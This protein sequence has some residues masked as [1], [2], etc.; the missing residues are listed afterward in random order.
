[1]D[2]AS[3]HTEPRRL[4]LLIAA[5]LA[6]ELVVMPGIMFDFL[7]RSAEWPVSLQLLV[8]CLPRFVVMLALVLMFGP[9]RKRLWFS[10]FLAAY[11]ALLVV[12]FYTAEVFVEWSSALAASRATFPYV[13]GVIAT[14]LGLWLGRKGQAKR[15][16]S[17][18]F[19]GT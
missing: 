14:A 13:A 18:R 7:A 8:P 4:L 16:R 3:E 1:V 10:G 6:V 15:I 9:F 11:M 17:P 19:D 2:C 5:S 12:R